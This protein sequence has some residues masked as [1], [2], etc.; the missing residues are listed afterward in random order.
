METTPTPKVAAPVCAVDWEALIPEEQWRCHVRVIHEAKRRGLPFACGGGM[1]YAA[2]AGQGRVTNDIDLIIKPE[3]RDL[4]VEVLTAA[5]FVD[6]FDEK[7]YDRTW[8]YRSWCPEC[9]AIC[10][11]IWTLPNHRLEVD[12]YWISGGDECVIRGERLRLIPPEEVVRAKLYI[13]QKDRCDWPDLVNVLHHSGH[14]MDWE[15]LIKQVG[16][17][18]PLLASLVNIYAWT[19]PREAGRLPQWLW[20]RLGLAEPREDQAE[21]GNAP[22]HWELLDSREWFGEMPIAPNLRGE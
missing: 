7:P 18:V 3:D 2:Y 17:D 10:D 6:Y 20:E 11:A 22:P 4:A 16:E 15:R 13:V 5:G 14:R 9:G 19:C 8:I 21:G 12:D 1:A